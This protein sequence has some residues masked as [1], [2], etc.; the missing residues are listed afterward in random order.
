MLEI[1]SHD[2][3]SAAEFAHVIALTVFV[4]INIAY[5]TLRTYKE[6]IDVFGDD[7]EEN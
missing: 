7:E 4:L 3:A 1:I 5:R 6:A 2:P